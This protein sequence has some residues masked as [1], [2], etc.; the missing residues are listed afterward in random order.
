MFA[1][2]QQPHNNS[3]HPRCF[4]DHKR[5][6]YLAVSSF[7]RLGD[8]SLCTVQTSFHLLTALCSKKTKVDVFF[9]DPSCIFWCFPKKNDTSNLNID[10]T[11]KYFGLLL[12]SKLWKYVRKKRSFLSVS[13]PEIPEDLVLGSFRKGVTIQKYEQNT[14]NLLGWNNIT[15]R[16]LDVCARPLLTFARQCTCA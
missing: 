1:L 11:S 13:S 12:F 4:K 3:D 10:T 6:I 7:E 14:P 15:V 2:N 5:H 8:T 9:F 16:T